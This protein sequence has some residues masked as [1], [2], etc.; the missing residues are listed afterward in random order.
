MRTAKARKVLR[1]A[2]DLIEKRGWWG[3]AGKTK[4]TSNLCAIQ[5]IGEAERQL[6]FFDP[7]NRSRSA[8]DM[9]R[10]HLDIR[11]IVEWNDTKGRTVDEVTKA[12]RGAANEASV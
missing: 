9:L 12:L 4:G 11:L 5:A 8:C 3:S 6:D 7:A 1:K 2:A 10:N